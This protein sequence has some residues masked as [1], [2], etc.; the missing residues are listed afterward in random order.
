MTRRRRPVNPYPNR[1][2]KTWTVVAADALEVS[3]K[4]LGGSP[5]DIHREVLRRKAL[6]GYLLQSANRHHP[7]RSL[8]D[9]LGTICDL[10]L[11]HIDAW[12]HLLHPRASLGSTP[13]GDSIEK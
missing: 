8:L 4:A 1:T 11:G 9:P 10:C 7:Y 12:Q 3:V 5:S 2:N 6:M 13:P